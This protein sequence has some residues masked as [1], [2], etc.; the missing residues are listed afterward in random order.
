MTLVELLELNRIG[1]TELDLRTVMPRN[2]QDPMD[3]KGSIAQRLT[4]EWLSRC[5][6]IIFDEDFP[7]RV[8]GYSLE[9]RGSGIAVY[10]RGKVVHEYDF[11]IIYNGQPV[12]VE[13]KSL[14][15][16]GLEAKIPRALSIGRSVY[17]VDDVQMLVFFPFYTNKVADAER[18]QANHPEVRCVNL[19]YKKRQLC[20][21]MKRFYQQLDR[22]AG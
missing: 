21:A 2:T 16:N 11:L 22:K 19:G 3:V 18:I 1:L 5:Q 13:V 4:E 10:E 6:G 17:G 8:N 20:A 9:I 15:L 14:K 12:I 7:R